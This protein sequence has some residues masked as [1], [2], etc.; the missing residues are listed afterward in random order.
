MLAIILTLQIGMGQIPIMACDTLEDALSMRQTLDDAAKGEA[1]PA[2]VRASMLRRN[3]KEQLVCGL[4]AQQQARPKQP[5]AIDQDSR[6]LIR[7]GSALLWQ[8]Q[9]FVIPL[10]PRKGI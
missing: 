1:S 2:D 9:Y 6:Y 5:V 10:S 4:I 8:R 7:E 3:D